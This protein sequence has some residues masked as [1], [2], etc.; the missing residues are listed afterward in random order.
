LGGDLA[1]VVRGWNWNARILAADVK[2]HS[3]TSFPV[4][5]MCTKDE[6]LKALNIVQ[7]LVSGSW[8]STS[9][10]LAVQWL[11]LCQRGFVEAGYGKK[12]E[13]L[14]QVD[15]ACF[16]RALTGLKDYTLPHELGHRACWG[17]LGGR[18]LPFNSSAA[19]VKAG[20]VA[21]CVHRQFCA[22][23]A[24]QWQAPLVPHVLTHADRTARHSAKLGTERS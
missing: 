2:L 20:A 11:K 21:I 6:V 23:A 10:T 19:A 8:S 4:E 13:L 3:G 17:R 1:A 22:P 12:A 7:E 15:S 18:M 14:L 9:A 24:P 5:G 16:Q